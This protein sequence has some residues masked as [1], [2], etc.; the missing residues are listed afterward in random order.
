MVTTSPPEASRGSWLNNRMLLS[1]DC[2][3]PVPEARRREVVGQGVTGSVCKVSGRK[4]VYIRDAHFFWLRLFKLTVLQESFVL[5]L[6]EEEEEDDLEEEEED[7]EEP[8]KKTWSHSPLGKGTK[9]K[10]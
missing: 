5:P 4:E 7:F 8:M 9:T 6:E 1:D 10:Q 2:V 3:L